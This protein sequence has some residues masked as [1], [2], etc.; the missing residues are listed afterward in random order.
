MDRK[1]HTLPPRVMAGTAAALLG[2]ALTGCSKSHH[3][4]A[5]APSSSASAGAAGTAAGATA[6]SGASSA[7]AAGGAAMSSAPA[8]GNSLLASAACALLSSSDVANAVGEPLTNLTGG[9][10]PMQGATSADGCIY[11]K[12]VTG[13]G[14]AVNIVVD[15]YSSAATTALTAQREQDTAQ[16]SQLNQA[17]ANSQVLK[18]VSVGDAAYELDSSAGPEEIVWFAKGD[19]L[20]EVDVTKGHPGAALTLA[21]VLA[22]KI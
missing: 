13:T 1:A 15:T 22:G 4:S 10:A 20:A 5:P 21:Q 3:A 17:V 6:S 16:A 12:D 18:A 2:I 14:A 8:V 19:K 11:T 7:A 9:R